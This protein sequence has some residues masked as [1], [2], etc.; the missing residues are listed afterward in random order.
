MDKIAEPRTPRDIA[1]GRAALATP[2]I[3]GTATFTSA[4][5]SR[6][7]VL[8][9]CLLIC[10]RVEAMLVRVTVAL[11]LLTG[12][13]PSMAMAEKRVALVIGNSAYKHAGELQNPKNDAA[14]IAAALK[15]LNFE[16]IE[17]RDST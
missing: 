1:G 8:G 7:K 17:G 11:L 14:D 3:P 16:V 15:A 10:I 13:L 12:L 4:A 5:L 2:A 6:M 9:W